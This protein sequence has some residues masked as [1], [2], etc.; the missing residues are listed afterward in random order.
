[1]NIE[2]VRPFCTISHK[3]KARYSTKRSHFSCF[4]HKNNLSLQTKARKVSPIKEIFSQFLSFIGGNYCLYGQK[5]ENRPHTARIRHNHLSFRLLQSAVTSTHSTKTA[6]KQHMLP[7]ALKCV[8]SC[9]VLVRSS[10][11]TAQGQIHCNT[12]S[13]AYFCAVCGLKR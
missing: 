6:L 12:E 11:S 10:V 4:S 9:A 7:M 8:L 2:E 13:Y 5:N 1:M 3:K